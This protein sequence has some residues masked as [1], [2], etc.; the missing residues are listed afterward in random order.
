MTAGETEIERQGKKVAHHGTRCQPSLLKVRGL[1][2][3]SLKRGYYLVS[4]WVIREEPC[5]F[6]P[7]CYCVS[8]LIKV[9]VV[10]WIV[11]L[12]H[13]LL[14]DICHF[15]VEEMFKDCWWICRAACQTTYYL[16]SVRC[17]S[18]D[19]PTTKFSH[20]TQ[21]TALFAFMAKRKWFPF[22]IYWRFCFWILLVQ[23]HT[24]VIP[25]LISLRILGVLFSQ[26]LCK[27]RI[28][29]PILWLYFWR[30]TNSLAVVDI[31]AAC[32]PQK[33]PTVTQAL[34]NSGGRSA[35]LSN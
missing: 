1:P 8:L 26:V 27:D 10:S 15:Q 18:T 32:F 2:R 9:K 11:S 33:W 34:T 12:C 35:L 22:S 16:E 28:L 24:E 19:V 23:Q 14:I 6:G 21:T 13:A 25:L 20:F 7:L 5:L 3:K 17:N 30:Q 29:F 4:T 31:Q